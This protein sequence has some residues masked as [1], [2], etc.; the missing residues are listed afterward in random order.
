MDN[1]YD[2]NMNIVY[3]GNNPRGTTCLEALHR[4]G[5]TPSA[6]VIHHGAPLTPGSVHALAKQLGLPVY[7]PRHVNAPEFLE[8]VRDLQPDLMILAGYNQI[9]KGD[10]L[11]IP[12]KGTINLHGGYLPYYRGGSPINWQIINGETIGGCAILYV[13]KGIDTGDI[14]TQELYEILPDVTAGEIVEKTLEIFPRLLI[15]VVKQIE[16]G[17]V[18]ATRQDPSLGVYYCKRYPQDGQIFWDRMT[19]LQV[20][21]LVRALNGQSLPGAFTFLN[22]EKI[23][24]VR[25]RLLD[26][27]IKGIPG[28][29]ALKWDEGIVIVAKDHGVLVTEVKIDNQILAAQKYFKIC[30]EYPD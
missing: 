9:L 30:H 23:V 2:V 22:E 12:L 27:I 17:T 11:R 29:I 3:F 28:R 5:F 15:D 20:H 24:I 4:S 13:D 25:T 21:N 26:S 10:I 1:V 8:Q 6:V 14:I 16:N 19:A 18:T 7:D